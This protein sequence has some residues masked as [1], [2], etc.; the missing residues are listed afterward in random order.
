MHKGALSTENWRAV[1]AMADSVHNRG[2]RLRYAAGITVTLLLHA[3]LLLLPISPFH[4]TSHTPV[5]TTSIISAYLR[6]PAPEPAPAAP[7]DRPADPPPTDPAPVAE[8]ASDTPLRQP[9]PR[10]P[11]SIQSRPSATIQP[12]PAVS[13][14]DTDTRPPA[15]ATLRDR[16]L[17]S[18]RHADRHHRPPPSRRLGTQTETR[19]PSQWRPTLPAEQD[20]AFEQA[21][22][23]DKAEVVDQWQHE[24]GTIE[25]R[26]RARDGDYYCGRREP[27]DP[28]EPINNNVQMWRRC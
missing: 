14:E 21:W 8:H 16:A 11:S 25:T 6:L 12:P 1:S 17:Q 20:T 5:E 19:L 18:A 26:V 3:S 2:Q 7:V 10:S 22:K 27:V 13:A 9:P 15:A 28:L 24:D 4:S 23:P